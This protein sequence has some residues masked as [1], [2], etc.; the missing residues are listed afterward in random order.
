MLMKEFK[1]YNISVDKDLNVIRCNDVFLNYIGTEKIFNLDQIIPPQDVM[2]L[3]NALFAVNPGYSG[4]TC[5][6]VRT[7]EGRLNWIAANIDKSREFNGPIN[8]E[9]SDIQTLKTEST[10]G[11]YDNMTGLFSKKS[12]T[13]HLHD[14]ID[15]GKKSFY[16]FLMDIDHFK[17]VNDTFGHM[18]GDEVITDVAHIIRD[19]IGDAGTVGRIGGDEFMLVFDNVCE[20]AMLRKYL[21]KIKDTVKEKYTNYL[22]KLDITVSLGGGLFPTYAGDYDSLFKLADGMLYR[23]KTKGRDRYII[24]TP[25]VHGKFDPTAKVSSAVD[26]IAMNTARINLV[27][28]FLKDFHEGKTPPLRDS[29]EQISKTYDIDQIYVIDHENYRSVCGIE[30]VLADNRTVI[31]DSA[32]EMSVLESANIKAMFNA[33]NLATLNIHEF[34]KVK[35]HDLYEFMTDHDFRSIEVCRLESRFFNGYITFISRSNSACRLSEAAMTDLIYISQ[36]L[37]LNGSIQ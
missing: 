17:A 30:K 6:R 5:F 18:R 12:I 33:T 15:E 26:N 13:G 35:M 20:E 36:I 7:F 23:A 3:R 14:L 11:I 29:L 34:D 2:Q 31:N 24:Y 28:G 25:L 8:L 16:L 9:L 21:G 27:K 37:S 10:D 22:D 32:I 1:K 4:F 19:I